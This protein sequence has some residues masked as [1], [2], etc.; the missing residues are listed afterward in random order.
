MGRACGTYGEEQ[1]LMEDFW[2]GN[3]KQRD[4]VGNLVVRM[5]IK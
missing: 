4:H 5:R 1:K 3:P 2:W